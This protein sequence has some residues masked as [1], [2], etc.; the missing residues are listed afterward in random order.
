MKYIRIFASV[1]L[2]LLMCFGLFGCTDSE[3]KYI[4][5]AMDEVLTL[6][7]QLVKNDTDRTV[8]LNIFEGL[9]RLDENDKPVPAVA[10]HYEYENL[11]YTFIIRPDVYWSD[12]T[13]LTAYD[14]EFAFRRAASPE[15][16][17]PDFSRISCIKGAKEVNGGAPVETLKV[18]ATGKYTL[19]ITLEYEDENFLK[20]LAS[21]ICMPCNEEFFK[22][23][24]GKYGRDVYSVLSNG[25][26][27]LNYWDSNDYLIRLYRNEHYTGNF[28]AQP[29]KVYLTAAK[30]DERMTL[31]TD[32]DIDACF[33]SGTDID[34]AATAGLKTKSYFDKYLFI[35]VNENSALGDDAVRK[36]LA[37]SIHRNALKNDMPS[38]IVPISAAIQL[39]ATFD[40]QEIYDRISSAAALGYEPDEAYKLYLDA[41]KRLGTIE[42]QSIIYPEEL[43]IDSLVSGLASSWQQNLG[44]FINMNEMPSGSVN[45]AIAAG[46]YSVA[47]LTVSAGSQNAYDLLS[48]FKSGNV[49]GFANQEFDTIINSLKTKT[50][51]EDYISALSSA[52]QLLLMDNTI[53]PVAATPTVICTTPAIESIDYSLA[54][55]FIDF[56]MIIKK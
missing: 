39:D 41:T 46:N 48:F 14:F 1:L 7:P 15:T 32:N 24:N 40:G 3:E 13:Q 8:S 22:S 33:V 10:S 55:K 16:A 4:Y 49:A 29:A 34:D 19:R 47:L 11:T 21:P 23:T 17:A 20:A 51:A 5:I 25:S 2:A 43:E 28:P 9:M 36:A 53:I 44:C 52:Q 38:H 35:L 31:L 27:S 45:S 37:M 42:A 12:G 6:D 26:F 54:N 18:Y 30:Q 50:V 56:A